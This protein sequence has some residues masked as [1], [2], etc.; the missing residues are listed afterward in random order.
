MAVPARS[1]RS[2]PAGGTKA[3][4]E[5]Q[6]RQVTG[7]NPS[8]RSQAEGTE[9]CTQELQTD[10]HTGPTELRDKRSGPSCAPLGGWEEQSSTQT[11]RT[12]P[13]R[14]LGRTEARKH[15][16]MTLLAEVGVG[17]EIRTAPSIQ[18]FFEGQ[19]P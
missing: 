16:I 13:G 9:R 5:T 12:T 6:G 4:E 19:V 17:Y 18:L 3:G 7:T 1:P 15:V 10:R 14:S 8:Y 11:G 2:G